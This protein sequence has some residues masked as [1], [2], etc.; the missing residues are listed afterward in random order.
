M[1]AARSADKANVVGA[2]SL[3]WLQPATMSVAAASTPALLPARAIEHH[4]CFGLVFAQ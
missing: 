3:F 2:V 4:E 1:G